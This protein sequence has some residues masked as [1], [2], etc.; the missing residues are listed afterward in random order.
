VR[1]EERE[2]NRRNELIRVGR[3][4]GRVLRL[5]GHNVLLDSDLAVLYDVP[6]RVL[7]QAVKRNR[8]RFPADFMFRLTRHEVDVLRSQSVT[9][10][11]G[12]GGR[13]HAPYAF[14]EQ[15]VAMLSSVL[16]SDRA[17]RVN[18]EIMRAF[19]R[20]RQVLDSNLKMAARLYE[21]ERRCD[22]RF[23]IVFT[24]IRELA[25]AKTKRSMRPIGFAPQAQL[26][27][28]RRGGAMRVPPTASSGSRRRAAR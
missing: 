10:R 11:S 16:R 8:E 5:R 23:S 26:G 2:M 7:N 1:V 20:L 22:E 12:H 25:P 13:R 24:A 14:T 6:A 17:V 21:L 15:G 19:V 4:E 9:S 18:V 27:L 3:I 28:P